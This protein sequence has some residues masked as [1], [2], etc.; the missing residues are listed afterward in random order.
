MKYIVV[1]IE[2]GYDWDDLG[3]EIKNFLNVS[4]SRYYDDE[5]KTLGVYGLSYSKNCFT[6]ESAQALRVLLAKKILN[7]ELES[8]NSAKE[9]FGL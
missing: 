5:G 6:K 1:E 3:E 9:R 8:W 7:G 2:D 4:S